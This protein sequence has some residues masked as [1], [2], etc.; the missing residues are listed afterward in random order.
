MN[1]Q[2]NNQYRKLDE[3]STQYRKF[4]KGQYIEHTQFNEFLDFFEDHDRLSRIMLQGVGIVCGLKP[5]LIYKNGLLSNMQLSQGAAVTTDGDLLTL[6]DAGKAGEDL[7][8][9][10]LRTID[11]QNKDY[12]HFKKY[13]DFKAQYPA[14]KKDDGSQIE[15]WELIPVQE[16]GSGT[17]PIGNLPDPED[18]YLLLYLE[19]YEKEVKPC[20]G[21]D[22]DNHGVQQIRNLKI[23]AATKSG[24]DHIL[25]KDRIRP[26]A[27]FVKDILEA[28]KQERVIIER[29]L[30]EQGAE[31]QFDTSHLKDLYLRAMEKSGYGASVFKKINTISQFIGLPAVD[32]VEF[33]SLL[34]QVL[35]QNTGFQYAYDVLKDLSDT[36]SEIIRVLPKSFTIGFP[37]LES[38]PKHVMLGKLGSDIQLDKYRHR[39]YNSPVLDDDK[40]TLQ[41][42]VLLN[43]FAQQVQNFKYPE[44]QEGEGI[45]ITPSR[46]SGP[47]G[48]KAIPFYYQITPEFLKV[49][50]FSKAARRL[51]GENLA[52]DTSLLSSAGHIQ[53][54][55]GFNIDKNTFYNIEGHQGMSRDEAYGQLKELRDRH[56]LGF[57]IMLLSFGELR[58]NKD[59]FKAYFNEY[60]GKHPGLEHKR[61]VGRG[62]TFVMIY[63]HNGRET[64]IIADFSIPYI[65]CTPKID[66]GL[67]LPASVICAEAAPIPFTVLPVGGMVKAVV[68]S[69]KTGVVLIDGK[70]FFDP[71]E[72]DESLHGQLIAFTVNGKPTGCTIKVTAQPD[73]EVKVD[74]VFY[75]E[76][77]SSAT[78]VVMLV[79]GENFKNYTYHWDFLDNGSFVTLSP[80]DE[81][82]LK[83]TLYD[84]NPA[85]IPTIKVKIEGSGC[86]QEVSVRDWYKELTQ[87]SLPVAEI[88]SDSEAIPFNVSPAGGIVEASAGGGV[89]FENGKYTFNPK[90]IDKSLHGQLITFTVNGQ[91]T[92]C[93]IK[94]MTKPQV[95]IDVTKV[96]Y[97][98]NGSSSTTVHFLVSEPG[99]KNYSYSWDFLEN[100]NFTTIPPDGDG[101]LIYTLTN[102]D[103][104]GIPV[105]KVKVSN[106]N[107]IQEIIIGN[108]WYN[109]PA[110]PSVVINSIGFPSGNCCE[111]TVQN[112]VSA[113]V[114]SDER[115]IYLSANELFELKGWASGANDFDYSWFQTYSNND[116]KLSLSES[117]KP[118]V[119]VSNLSAGIYEFQFMAIDIATGAF[120]TKRVKVSIVR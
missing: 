33:T 10:D 32:H 83:Y 57:D 53:N 96:D 34:K 2:S 62:G 18:K 95:K 88:C 56:Q 99:F 47:L 43:R 38:F 40:E 44:L 55:V 94:V 8:V 59:L 19:S 15:L 74:Y 75:P 25:E 3:V 23:L 111:G 86:T 9:S 51:S 84:V 71:R 60:V 52:Y 78:T 80:D 45:K 76:G 54:P 114:E 81:G 106:G 69:E 64:G 118:T 31:A 110:A 79:S 37:D 119:V 116:E 29:L 21:V 109:P 16:A 42:K 92:N 30:L 97:P 115:T 87:L 120:D 65:C 105:I 28:E 63:E 39:F 77:N 93:S 35:Q 41:V 85:R 5:N 22:C 66:A 73:I 89:K 20:R 48:R 113:F 4:S 36:C 61:G 103:K 67:S 50:N 100:G 12:T 17:Q 107:C 112:K 82:R 46:K 90:L 27:L 91:A 102:L 72:L 13:D 58:D 1:N 6:K 26:H 70:Y 108:T 49:W 98:G 101:N 14:F 117:N 24:I 11:L 68:D 7:Y 104:T